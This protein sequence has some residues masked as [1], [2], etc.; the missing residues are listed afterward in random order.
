MWSESKYMLGSLCGIVGQEILLSVLQH[1]LP[2]KYHSGLGRGFRF[3]VNR[4]IFNRVYSSLRN[5]VL[6]G[7]L[8]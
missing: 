2:I 6:K 4:R 3:K 8:Y 1:I 7:T 5:W